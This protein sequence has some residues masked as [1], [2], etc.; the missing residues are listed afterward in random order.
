MGGWCIIKLPSQHVGNYQFCLWHFSVNAHLIEAKIPLI[1]PITVIILNC[2]YF[3]DE[4]F[5]PP[6][7][8]SSSFQ[9]LDCFNDHYERFGGKMA[10]LSSHGVR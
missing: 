9:S 7:R 4:V 10:N 1:F 6:E 8:S 5:S 3:L 2:R